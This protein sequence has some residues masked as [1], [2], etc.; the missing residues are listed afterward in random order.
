MKTAMPDALIS[1]IVPMLNEREIVEVTLGSLA[2]LVAELTG[3]WEVIIVDA[4]S[5]DGT[6]EIAEGVCARH[7]WRFCDAAGATRSVGGTVSAGAAVARG[8]IL[9]VLPADTSV[10]MEG[11]RELRA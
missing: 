10:G 3:P 7:G 11:L 4:G 9:L 5:K 1:L 2:H 6:R 8:E